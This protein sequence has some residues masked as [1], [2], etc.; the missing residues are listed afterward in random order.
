M[1]MRPVRERIFV[2]SIDI[3]I[4]QAIVVQTHIHE[5]IKSRRVYMS[6]SLQICIPKIYL[7][8][9]GYH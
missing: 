1:T 4:A 7:V 8:I 5:Q 9:S 2:S 3:S 6:W